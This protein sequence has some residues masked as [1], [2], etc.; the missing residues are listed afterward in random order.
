[1][2]RIH[3]IQPFYYLG[4]LA[5]KD[6]LKNLRI[7]RV[8]PDEITIL[9]FRYFLEKEKLEEALFALINKHLKDILLVVY[10]EVPNDFDVE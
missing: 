7:I 2:L 5:M 9:T 4:D 3:C 6:V 8:M 1:M 10:I